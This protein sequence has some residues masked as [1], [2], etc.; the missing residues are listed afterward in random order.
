MDNLS[1]LDRVQYAIAL[2]ESHFREFK[3][4]LH[5]APADKKPRNK[6]DIRRDIA[7]ALVAFAN[8][9]GGDILIGVED[10]GVITGMPHGQEDLDFLRQTYVELIQDRVPLPVTTATTLSLDGKTILFFSVSKGSTTIYQLSDGRCVQ[11]KDK[12]TIPISFT[13]IQFERQEVRSREW[14]RQFVDGALA[15]D[16]DTNLIHSLADQYLTGLSVER[17][18]QQL[19]LAEYS[20]VGLRLRMSALLLFAKD[21]AKWQPRVQVRILKV[22]GVKLLTGELYNV[23]ADETTTGNI[24][25][26][27]TESW[28]RLRPY[29]TSKNEFGSDARFEQRFLYPE[30]VAREALINAI[31]HR[32]YSIQNPIEIFIFDDRMEIKN[33]GALLSTITVA[34]LRLL[35]GVHESRNVLIAKVLRENKYVREL[36]EG[37]RRMFELMKGF[38]LEEPR[39][40]SNTISFTVTLSHQSV[41]TPQQQTWLDIF[42]TY[43]LTTRQKKIVVQGMNSRELSRRDIEDAMSTNDRDTYDREVTALRSAGILAQTLTQKQA[44]ALALTKRLSHNAI[45]R[46]RVIQPQLNRARG[47]NPNQR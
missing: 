15:A 18:L 4:A 42:A 41:F 25:Q 17:Y 35:E 13:N 40:Y 6:T 1:T 2:G 23:V 10:D 37:F 43:N 36:G 24:F 21:I 20:A 47:F 31:T 9:D 16:L 26:L 30:A 22:N 5:G 28:E 11:R 44:R 3:S 19:G 33:P 8:A 32:D 34:S 39:L 38:A 27:L 14:D 12:E 29:L 7:E 45:P 46:F